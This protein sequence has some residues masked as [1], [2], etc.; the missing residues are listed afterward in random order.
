MQ[1]ANS[2]VANIASTPA[3][4][5]AR[6]A[7][8][9]TPSQPPGSSNASQYVP[10]K[11]MES[12]PTIARRRK[13][14]LPKEKQVSEKVA[15]LLPE[16]ALYTQLLDYEAQ[17]DDTLT[18]RK[19]DIQEVIRCPPH[20]Q[21]TLRMYVFNTFSN[22]TKMGFEKKNAEESSWSLKIT[23]RIL[24]DGNDPVS[25][26]LQR[27]S[28]S[29]PRF[30]AFFKKITI[31]LDQSLYPENHVI[32]WDSACSPIQL[33][34]FGVKRKGDKEFTAVIRIEMNYSPEKFMVSTQLSKLLGVEV[35]TRPRIIAALW[36]YVK[37][38]KLQCPR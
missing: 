27:S 36:H 31:S 1:N 28:P 32:L 30:S 15:A 29:Y 2:N 7:T 11:T 9:K 18:R 19:V 6:R 17:M 20:A 22:P 35:E 25:R 21:K 24:E 3:I 4:G 38:M 14:E 13:R 37:F 16:S 12:A 10:L 23:G 34:G 33:D 26:I 8:Q 5:S